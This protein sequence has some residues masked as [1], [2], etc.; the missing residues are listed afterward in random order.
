[1]LIVDAQVQERAQVV[2]RLR[3][4]R[5]DLRLVVRRS[6]AHVDDQP[7]VGEA[8]EAGLAL[9]QDLRSQDVA[10]ER[11]RS[12]NV[13]DDERLRSCSAHGGQQ[14]WTLWSRYVTNDD[15]TRRATPRV[16]LRSVAALP[17][18]R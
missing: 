16:K 6:A 15:G 3:R 2:E 5:R 8:Q 17:K 1:M 12:S 14:A 11:D 7:G 18:F 9:S 4:S 10:I 13:G